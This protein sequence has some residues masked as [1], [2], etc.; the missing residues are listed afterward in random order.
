METILITGGLGFIGSHT[1][2]KFRAHGDRIIV[3]DNLSRPHTAFQD[4]KQIS[5]MW[6]Y[7]DQNYPD[8]QKYKIDICNYGDLKDIFIKH[9]PTVIIHTAG[10]T[11]AVGSIDNPRYDFENNVI[12]LFNTLDLARTTG[13]VKDFIFLSTNKVYGERVNEIPLIEKESRY[14]PKNPGFLGIS[15]DFPIDNSKHTP[16]GISKL[17]GDLY[18]QEFGRLYGLNT[19]CFRMSC[20]YGYRQFGFI[21]QGWIS[22]LISQAIRNQPIPIFGTGKQVRDILFIDDLTDLYLKYILWKGKPK[23]GVYNIGGGID[24]RISLIEAIQLIK[25]LHGN[26]IHTS[27][28]P[29]RPGD[30][31]YY[32][33]DI[34]KIKKELGWN[35]K[36][37]VSDGIAISY[38]WHE[39][40]S[41][42]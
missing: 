22:Y 15:E 26:L 11:S 2:E 3:V 31:R 10:Q 40:H 28:H 29:E 4:S 17:T 12:G 23:I 19:V 8:I 21:E 6:N 7:F 41:K 13:T 9:Q 33:S 25:N 34:S 36:T 24:N 30:Q 1:A 5:Y 37:S 42:L 20:I 18:V 38:R 27:S 14:I 32:V 35:P 16:Y 39:E